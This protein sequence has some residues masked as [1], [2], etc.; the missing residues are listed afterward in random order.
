[1]NTET[2]NLLNRSYRLSYFILAPD[3]KILNSVYQ[4]RADIRE[5]FEMA[6]YVENDEGIFELD[7]KE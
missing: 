5:T 4:L 3:E 1:M 6:G 2:A 7:T